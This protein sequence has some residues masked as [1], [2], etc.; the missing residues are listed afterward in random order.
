MSGMNPI[1]LMQL[2]NQYHNY[3]PEGSL[4]TFKFTKNNRLRV[5]KESPEEGKRRKSYLSENTRTIVEATLRAKLKDSLRGRLNTVWMENPEKLKK[6][7]VPLQMSTGQSGFGVLPTGSRVPI[8]EGK[9]VRAFTYWE[10]VND[11]DLS[12]FAIDDDGNKREEF[13]WRT[14]WREDSKDVAFSGDETY[15]YNGGS[16]YIDFYL[17]RFTAHHPDFHYLIFCDNIFSSSTFA[18][19][20]AKGGF[21]LRDE[22]SSGEIY[23]PKTVQTSYRLTADSTFCYMFAIDLRRREMVWLNIAREGRYA[24]AGTTDFGF[25]RDYLESTD[26]FN[27]YDLFTA[28]AKEI[29]PSP[30]TTLKKADVLVTDDV[31]YDGLASRDPNLTVIHSWDLEKML[32]IIQPGVKE[33]KFK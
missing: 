24:V 19:C 13:S 23:E 18:N 26:V 27:A 6:L 20:E 17:R 29:V 22:L 14:F 12:C 16:E 21:M 3:K 33:V 30:T 11:I 32:A 10:K 28:A 9:I 25:I 7:A 4:R 5:H 31:F 2:L 15:G 1:I 8:P